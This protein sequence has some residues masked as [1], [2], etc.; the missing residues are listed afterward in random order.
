MAKN[1]QGK[2]EVPKGICTRIVNFLKEL[3]FGYVLDTT[4]LLIDLRINSV[5]FNTNYR[6]HYALLP[7][8]QLVRGKVYWGSEETIEELRKKLKTLEAVS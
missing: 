7:Y 3:P 8:R 1:A 4:R 5:S 6:T 2:D